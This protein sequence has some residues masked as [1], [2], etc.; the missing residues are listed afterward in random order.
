[1]RQVANIT[2]LAMMMIVLL[3]GIFIPSLPDLDDDDDNVGCAAV[4]PLA[5]RK[6]ESQM[7]RDEERLNKAVRVRQH[8]PLSAEGVGS[9]EMIAPVIVALSQ[10]TPPLRS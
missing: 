8:A 4:M 10:V 9:A 5:P 2:S 7:A 1:M 3:L 6:S